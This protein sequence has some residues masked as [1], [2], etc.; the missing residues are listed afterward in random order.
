MWLVGAL[1]H[2]HVLCLFTET[3]AAPP[4]P[5]PSNGLLAPTPGFAITCV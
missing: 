4:P 3:I 1:S 2:P 5:Y